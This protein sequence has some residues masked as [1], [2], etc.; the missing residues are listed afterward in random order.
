VAVGVSVIVQVYRIGDI[1][2]QSVWG[3]EI[4]RLTKANTG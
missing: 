1:G 4:A 3:G 2:S